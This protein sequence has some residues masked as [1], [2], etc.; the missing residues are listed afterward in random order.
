MDGLVSPSDIR[1]TSYL[2]PPD[3]EAQLLN[4]FNEA[5]NIRGGAKDGLISLADVDWYIKRL[6]G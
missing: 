6:G 5:D 1:A 2:L 3:C 4:T